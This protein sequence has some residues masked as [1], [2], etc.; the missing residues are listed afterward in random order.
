[1]PDYFQGLRRIEFGGWLRWLMTK[2]D[3]LLLLV[4]QI[5]GDP[6]EIN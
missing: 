1:M 2:Q 5:H 3:K 6:E 4:S